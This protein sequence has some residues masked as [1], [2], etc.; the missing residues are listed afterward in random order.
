MLAAQEQIRGGCSSEMNGSSKMDGFD[1]IYKR[2]LRL[3]LA[4]RW[5]K[6]SNGM[7]QKLLE[8]RTL[9][10]CAGMLVDVIS[11]AG[12]PLSAYIQAHSEVPHVEVLEHVSSIL[13]EYGFCPTEGI[14]DTINL[15][16]YDYKMTDIKVFLSA[17]MHLADGVKT[18]STVLSKKSSTGAR[19][20]KV[21]RK[22]EDRGW[23][24]TYTRR[25]F[26][27]YWRSML[28]TR[29]LV[30]VYPVYA[31]ADARSGRH[32]ER[33]SVSQ[34]SPIINGATPNHKLG[35]VGRTSTLPSNLHAKRSFSIAAIG[36]FRLLKLLKYA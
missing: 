26:F 15:R 9:I 6:G 33:I 20:R 23:D 17:T 10:D 2:I 8:E 30:K 19:L 31:R 14:M 1:V 16:P 34:S 29:C 28:R 22:E 27:P 11:Y 18:A 24:P 21:A 7:A 4:L 5:E 12:E 36:A 25:S 32:L 13:K 3:S 35:L